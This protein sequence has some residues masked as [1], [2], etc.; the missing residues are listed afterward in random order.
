M[1]LVTN[2]YHTTTIGIVPPKLSLLIYNVYATIRF[3]SLATTLFFLAI[4]F[5]CLNLLHLLKN[6]RFVV[7]VLYVVVTQSPIIMKLGCRQ[8]PK[9]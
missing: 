6:L 3:S 9:L 5:F 8:E 7:V 2:K 1:K 4:I